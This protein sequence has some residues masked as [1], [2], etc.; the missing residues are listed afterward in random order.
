M[1]IHCSVNQQ[2]HYQLSLQFTSLFV[3]FKDSSVS[4]I[5]SCTCLLP[6]V[7][8]QCLPLLSQPLFLWNKETSINRGSKQMINV[9]CKKP[10]ESALGESSSIK[11]VILPNRQSKRHSFSPQHGWMTFAERLAAGYLNSHWPVFLRAL[12]AR[13]FVHQDL[14]FTFDPKDFLL[15][16]SWSLPR[17]QTPISTSAQWSKCV[18]NVLALRAKLLS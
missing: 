18:T 12:P 10:W 8:S 13:P 7:L 5:H 16:L 3:Y 9:V 14:S 2:E 11:V 17:H 6:A 15:F 4:L 1:V